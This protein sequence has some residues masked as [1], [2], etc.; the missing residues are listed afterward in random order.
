MKTMFSLSVVG[1]VICVHLLFINGSF[2]QTSAIEMGTL[3]FPVIYN[4][5]IKIPAVHRPWYKRFYGWV[6]RSPA[7][8]QNV[9]Y[10]FPPQPPPSSSS[11]NQVSDL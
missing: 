4:Q 5:T 11:S 8:T 10:I 1:A 3:K 6:S 9:T 7:P 2:G